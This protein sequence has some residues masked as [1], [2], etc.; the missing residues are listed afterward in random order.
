MLDFNNKVSDYGDLVQNKIGA[1]KNTMSK[2][3]VNDKNFDKLVNRYVKLNQNKRFKDLNKTYISVYKELNELVELVGKSWGKMFVPYARKNKDKTP[4]RD[5]EMFCG[6]VASLLQ[7]YGQFLVCL[8]INKR[9][10]MYF[11]TIKMPMN[12]LASLL[13]REGKFED[14]MKCEEAERI[15]TQQETFDKEGLAENILTTLKM[16]RKDV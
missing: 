5:Q 14:F 16:A 10:R 8:M 7:Q 6:E 15:E 13:K 2:I 3:S 11:P 1:I 12:A 9:F 4:E